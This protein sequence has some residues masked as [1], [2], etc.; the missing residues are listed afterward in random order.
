LVVSIPECTRLVHIAAGI[1]PRSLDLSA[2]VLFTQCF[3]PGET[4]A[5]RFQSS[6]LII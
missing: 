3:V 2:E 5:S 6:S 4:L 1:L